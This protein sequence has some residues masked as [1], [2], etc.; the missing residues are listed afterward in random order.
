MSTSRHQ[1]IAP[2]VLRRLDAG[3]GIDAHRHDDHQIAYAARGV[4][5]V[6]TDHGHWIAPA[7]R[8]IWI[9]AGAVHQHR[10]YG[11]TDLHLVGLT[12]NP[13]G[14]T[15]PA[16][17]AVGPLLRELIIAHTNDSE[18]TP[19]ERARL[20]GVLLDQLQRTAQQPLRLPLARDPRLAA[21]CA[22]LTSNPADNSSL[23]G[24]G[25]QAGASERTLSRL[26]RTEFAMTFPQ[27]R[28]QLRLHH[29]LILLAEGHAV[30]TV[31]IRCGWSTPSAFIDTFRQTFGHTPGRHRP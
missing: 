31:A 19:A 10:A 26:F 1:P 25:L 2:T 6:A 13:L 21:A 30:T 20:R 5:A 8:A 9:P 23:A 28:T 4:L 11:R 17:L 24:L 18:S 15:T 29:A 12:E 16:V 27:W 22:V 7:N 3:A 14:L